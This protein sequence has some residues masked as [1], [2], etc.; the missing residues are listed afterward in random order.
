MIWSLNAQLAA[1]SSVV[2][3][4]PVAAVWSGR[5]GLKIH[6]SHPRKMGW[7]SWSNQPFVGS[8][9]H[10]TYNLFSGHSRTRAEAD[11]NSA[12][13]NGRRQSHS[14]QGW[15]LPITTWEIL[16]MCP[17]QNGINAFP[18]SICHTKILPLA[19]FSRIPFKTL[20]SI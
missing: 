10:S 2:H 5:N 3:N 15:I 6:D 16:T 11:Y 18:H 8:F 4:T 1:V 13:V 20:L 14:L 12:D 19:I 7:E 17:F 9:I